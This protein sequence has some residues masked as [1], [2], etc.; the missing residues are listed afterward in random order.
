MTLSVTIDPT[1]RSRL[2]FSQLVT[3]AQAIVFLWPLP[4]KQAAL[5]P[6]PAERTVKGAQRRFIIDTSSQNAL[7]GLRLDVMNQYLS[8]T[9]IQ[10]KEPA[11]LPAWLPLHVRERILSFSLFDGV[12]RFAGTDPWGDIVVWIKRGSHCMRVEAYQEFPEAVEY[13]LGFTDGDHWTANLLLDV[14]TQFNADIRY[15]VEKKAMS[16]SEARGEIRRINNEVFKLVLE[17]S[18]TIMATGATISAMNST[19]R[20]ISPKIAAV[21][22]RSVPRVRLKP[23]NGKVNVGGGG[24]KPGMTNLNP[25]KPGSGGPTSGIPDHVRASMEEMDQIFEPGSVTYVT[26]VKVR[27]DDFNWPRAAKAASNVMPPGGKVFMNV[28]CDAD[29]EAFAIVAAFESA[30]FQRAWKQDSGPATIIHAIR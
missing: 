29:E 22:R 25:I 14:Y 7:M 20:L 28:L 16:P 17:A 27:V 13:Y 5:R 6:D 24:E 4:P 21:A 18:A 26:S 2:V 8:I 3:L 23:L 10:A 1:D 11:P 30:G 12:H 15:F 9:P 19:M